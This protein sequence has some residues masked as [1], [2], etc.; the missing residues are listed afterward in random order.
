M[1]YSRGG[2]PSFFTPPQTTSSRR[3]VRG[4]SGDEVTG[5]TFVDEGVESGLEGC[6]FG[7]F[8]LLLTPDPAPPAVRVS[9]QI[10][11]GPLAQELQN[12]LAADVSGRQQHEDLHQHG[13]ES[14]MPV[15]FQPPGSG[16]MHLAVA[17]GQDRRRR[18]KEKSPWSR[19]LGPSRQ[20]G[21]RPA[22][23]GSPEQGSSF[24]FQLAFHPVSASIPC[25]LRTYVVQ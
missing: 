11:A 19:R 25:G 5:E 1:G 13:G 14:R 15:G 22:G 2:M 3:I 9:R 6:V 20:A 16:P 23:S 18:L 10:L 4:G 12:V 7:M 8:L 24:R 21:C 17:I